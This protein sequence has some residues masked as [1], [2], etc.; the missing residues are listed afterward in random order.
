MDPR[1]SSGL[2]N[3]RIRIEQPAQTADSFGQSSYGPQAPQGTWTT[4]ITCWANIE[5]AGGKEL[6]D[7]SR[8]ISQSPVTIN[9]RYNAGKNVTPKMRAIDIATGDIYDIRNTSHLLQA[10]RIIQLSCE[11]VK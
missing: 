6:R 9:V 7:A 8:E 3:R 10:R 4:V 11:V 5:P 1:A 2:F